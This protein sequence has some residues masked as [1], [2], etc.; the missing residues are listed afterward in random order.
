MKSK[1]VVVKQVNVIYIKIINKNFNIN[2][3][4][5]NKILK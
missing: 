1:K 3:K 2:K 4:I 5:K